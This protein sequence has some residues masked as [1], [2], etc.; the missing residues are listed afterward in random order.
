MSI[1]WHIMQSAC[2]K[3]LGLD[4]NEKDQIMYP[5]KQYTYRKKNQC[6]NNQI[7][8]HTKVSIHIQHLSMENQS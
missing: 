3:K 6:N 8:M 5:H 2:W 7:S 4:I 1:I